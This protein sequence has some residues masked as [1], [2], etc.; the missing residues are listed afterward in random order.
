MISTTLAGFTISVKHFS[1]L[2]TGY[3]NHVVNFKNESRSHSPISL[4][5]MFLWDKSNSFP[6]YHTDTLY[7]LLSSMKSSHSISDSKG[8]GSRILK[9]YAFRTA[10]KFESWAERMIS[11]YYPVVSSI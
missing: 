5:V 10:A 7:F 2:G 11:L 1:E 6:L 9:P 4:Q 3:E 8:T